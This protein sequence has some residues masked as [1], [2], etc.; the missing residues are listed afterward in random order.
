M[1]ALEKSADAYTLRDDDLEISFRRITD[2][3]QHLVSVQGGAGWELLLASEEGMPADGIPP[4]PVFQDLHFEEL[5]DGVF[6]FQL[7]GQAAKGIYSA[8]V[9]FDGN[10]HVIDFDVCG[11]GRAAGASFCTSSAYLLSGTGAPAAIER[12]PPG[13]ILHAPVLRAPGRR[14]IEIVPILIPESP[15]SECRALGDGG[16]RRIVAG[17]FGEPGSEPRAKSVS[18]RWR[19]RVSVAG[20]P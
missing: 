20:H 2:R 1:I 8:A 3:W 14:S 11:R 16:Q 6:E 18:I 4:G 17:C 7:L 9:R 5:R 13:L 15:P 12:R 10:A 19:Y